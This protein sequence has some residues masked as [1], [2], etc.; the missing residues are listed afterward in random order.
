MV[1]S[2]EIYIGTVLLEKNR[3]AARRTPTF[4]VSEWLDRFRNDGF[5]G[6]ELWAHH[7]DE[8]EE[9]ALLEASSLSIP[10]FNSYASFADTG[11]EERDRAVSLVRR[12]NSPFIK[13][14]IGADP[15]LRETYMKNLR[16]WRAEIPNSVTLLCECHPGTLIED[17]VEA[18]RFFDEMGMESHGII[19]H[20]FNR[21][22]TLAEWFELFGPAITHAHLQMRDDDD[23]MVRFDRFPQRARK[24]LSILKSFDFQGS[25]TLEFT[26]GTGSP[27][28]NIEDL[29]ENAQRD[30]AC[31]KDILGQ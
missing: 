2:T 13:Y 4:Q 17:A 19:V 30:L 5:S 3:W 25:F 31:L 27:Y 10:I 12:L 8:P 7:A 15:V 1:R 9:L 20:P 18:R 26:E 11:Q 21:L 6:V 16:T 29:Y 14:N 22:D 23:G 28:E 24:A